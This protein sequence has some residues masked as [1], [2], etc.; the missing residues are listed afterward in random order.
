MRQLWLIGCSNAADSPR[1]RAA[2]VFFAQYQQQTPPALQRRDRCDRQNEKG[3][4]VCHGARRG[5]LRCRRALP[6]DRRATRSQASCRCRAR[7][8]LRRS[9]CAEISVWRTR[10]TTALVLPSRPT[11]CCLL[12]ACWQASC[13]RLRCHKR[14][15][16]PSAAAL[17]T[18]V[19]VTELQAS[20]ASTFTWCRP[21]CRRHTAARSRGAVCR[22]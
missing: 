22:R 8:R 15:R 7:K 4:R 13:R 19:R 10:A 1:N 5:S 18:V 12:P 20:V 2:S 17:T 3:L 21:C 6:R 16:R 11:R 9:A 14:A